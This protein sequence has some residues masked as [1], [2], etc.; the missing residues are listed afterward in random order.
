MRRQLWLTADP[1]S[2][3]CQSEKL[4]KQRFF[5]HLS[6]TIH[7]LQYGDIL[8]GILNSYVLLLELDSFFS[9]IYQ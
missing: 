4:K 1:D 9:Q 6:R 2:L 5:P 3:V 8:G 7:T